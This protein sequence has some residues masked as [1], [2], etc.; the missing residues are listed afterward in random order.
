LR[1]NEVAAGHLVVF[2]D[3]RLRTALEGVG[4]GGPDADVE[5]GAAARDFRAAVFLVHHAGDDAA[6]LADQRGVAHGRVAH[7]QTAQRTDR[8]RGDGNG[9]HGAGYQQHGTGQQLKRQ[10]RYQRQQPL[11]AQ[12]ADRPRDQHQQAHGHRERNAVQ[13]EGHHVARKMADVVGIAVRVRVHAD[14]DIE[15]AVFDVD[16]AEHREHPVDHHDAQQHRVD[17]GGVPRHRSHEIA[18]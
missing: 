17:R 2:E 14:I 18:H 15:P 13:A 3:Q 9:D 6:E 8:H 16:H 11:A 1:G 12:A 5:A 10:C 7:E 4:R